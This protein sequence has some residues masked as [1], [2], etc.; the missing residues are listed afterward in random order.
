MQVLDYRTP[1]STPCQRH[2]EWG[3]ASLIFGVVLLVWLTLPFWGVNPDRVDVF[4]NLRLAGPLM[5]IVG[6]VF[7][8]HG[9][10]QK[11]RENKY[12]I[13]ALLLNILNVL[14]AAVL[15]ASL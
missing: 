11:G 12:A 9:V 14:V 10:F 3:L 13:L 5:G 8:G 1:E 6:I 15:W 7:A 2:S 4:H